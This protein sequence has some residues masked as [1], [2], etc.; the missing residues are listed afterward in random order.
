MERAEE[1]ADYYKKRF[2]EFGSNVTTIGSWD[3]MYCVEEKWEVEPV[4]YGTYAVTGR[5]VGPEYEDYIIE[6]LTHKIATGL[7]ERNLIQ[8]TKNKDGGPFD[9]AIGIKLFVVPWERM[10]HEHS[11]KIRRFLHDTYL[12]GGI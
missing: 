3:G 9:S 7:V 6:E 10:P 4:S 8:V 12:H 1:T 11:I 2:R 5:D